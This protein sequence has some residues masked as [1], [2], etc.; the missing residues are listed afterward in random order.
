[1]SEAKLQ[2]VDSDK[3][4]LETTHDLLIKW[5]DEGTMPT[6]IICA[7]DVHALSFLLAAEKLGIDVPGQ[8]SVIGADN[9][10]LCEHSRPRLT[11]INQPFEDMGTLAASKLIEIINSPSDSPLALLDVSLIKRDSCARVK[12]LSVKS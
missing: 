3:S 12:G 5:Q 9:V 7:A 1:M 4:S 11:S 2:F 8:L 6:A 10:M